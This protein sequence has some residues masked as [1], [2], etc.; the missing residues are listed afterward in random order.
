VDRHQR[1]AGNIKTDVVTHLFP[2]PDEQLQADEMTS[3]ENGFIGSG[4]LNEI[5]DFF[6]RIQVDE[7]RKFVRR[8]KIGDAM[9][10]RRLN[11]K[12]MTT[13][14]ELNASEFP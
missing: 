5:Q 3:N 2:V 8:C 13:L 6:F 10:M 4:D 12:W 1:R 14:M 11:T 7:D 9:E